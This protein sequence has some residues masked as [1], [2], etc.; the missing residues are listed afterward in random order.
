MLLA[1]VAAQETVKPKDQSGKIW[2]IPRGWLHLISHLIY[3]VAFTLNSILND[4]PCF[5]TTC[6][7]N[8]YIE[9]IRSLEPTARSLALEQLLRIEEQGAF[10]GLVGSARTSNRKATTPAAL[11]AIDDT[12]I[13]DE[14][15]NEDDAIAASVA[16]SLPR[17][18]DSR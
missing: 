13:D 5:K 9:R 7:S 10:V 15:N 17:T 2:K 11:L 4:T 18:I 8:R 14:D 16:I 3:Q 1:I 12:S 6:C